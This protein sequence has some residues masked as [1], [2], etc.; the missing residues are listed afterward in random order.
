[1]NMPPAARIPMRFMVQSW[2]LASHEQG[3]PF[4]QLRK[5]YCKT[6]EPWRRSRANPLACLNSA[7]PLSSIFHTRRVKRKVKQLMIKRGGHLSARENR[8]EKALSLGILQ[9]RYFAQYLQI[10]ITNGLIINSCEKDEALKNKPMPWPPRLH[11]PDWCCAG[12]DW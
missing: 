9:V 3:R 10:G 12:C 4:V 2:S 11:E 6:P 1:M 5:D 7:L 8:N